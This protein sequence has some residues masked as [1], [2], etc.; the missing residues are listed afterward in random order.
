MSVSRRWKISPNIDNRRTF[1]QFHH[2][3]SN[4]C[5]REEN[6]EN[7]AKNINSNIADLPKGKSAAFKRLGNIMLDNS[8][9]RSKRAREGD[10][11]CD[12]HEENQNDTN[13]NLNYKR[14]CTQ[15]QHSLLSEYSVGD[16]I[17]DISTAQNRNGNSSQIPAHI[18]Q[19]EQRHSEATKDLRMPMMYC[20][21]WP[22][23]MRSL[24][25]LGDR[26]QDTP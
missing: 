6:I 4:I 22:S 23:A 14:L 3:N 11:F 13:S 5:S 17:T 15:S 26:L 12:P 10:V 9:S 18:Q 24:R 19:H 21:F 25:S 8:A 7:R 2:R 1:S 20:P 16:S